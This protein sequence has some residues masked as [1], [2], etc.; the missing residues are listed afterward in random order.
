MDPARPL[1]DVFADLTGG[2]DT[3]PSDPSAV[4]AANGH[5]GLPAGLVAEAVGSY[6]DNAPIEVAEHLSPYVMAHSAVPLP[7]APEVDPGGW[8]DAVAGA[9]PAA[10]YSD[11]PPVDEPDHAFGDHAFGDDA[12]GGQDPGTGLTAHL[13]AHDLAGADLGGHDPSALDDDRGPAL[14]FGQGDTAAGAIDDQHPAPAHAWD[15]PP[16]HADSPIMDPGP[17]LL[18]DGHE[19]VQP[20]TLDDSV[21]HHELH[22]HAFDP[23]PDD[24]AD[25][26]GH[27]HGLDD[28]GHHPAG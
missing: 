25:D 16:T 21:E 10:D 6:A 9:P 26:L 28:P 4:L 24:A 22:P 23:I 27:E 18:F 5:P 1:R 2:E 7:D 15:G 11:L 3:G 17:D 20:D 8:L 12:F 14:H 13:A 19:A